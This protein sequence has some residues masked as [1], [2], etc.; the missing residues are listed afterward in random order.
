MLKPCSRVHYL[1]RITSDHA[2]HPRMLIQR[3]QRLMRWTLSYQRLMTGERSIHNAFKLQSTSVV[4]STARPLM[5]SLL[6]LSSLIKFAC[7]T[8]RQF[9]WVHK[10]SLIV[11]QINLDVKVDMSIKFLILEKRKDLLKQNAWDTT[12]KKANVKSNIS[13]LTNAESKMQ[14]G[15]WTITALLSKKRTSR[16]N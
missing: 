4:N 9:N 16:E 1:T 3:T 12:V 5:L 13:K 2:R 10:K 15:K 8:T 7:P 14:F 6:S 11:I